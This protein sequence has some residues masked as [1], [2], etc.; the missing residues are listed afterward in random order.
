MTYAK[1]IVLIYI[2]I[3]TIFFL[4]INQKTKKKTGLPIRA[5]TREVRIAIILNSAVFAAA[6][7][8]LFI[9]NYSG[10]SLPISFLQFKLLELIG[11]ISLFISLI[12]GIISAR[13]LGTSWRFGILEKQKIELVQI[14]IY[15]SC[16]N[17][18]FLSYY[19]MYLALFFI[20]PSIVLFL[21]IILT[22]LWFHKMVKEEERYLKKM[23]GSRYLNYCRKVHRY[24]PKFG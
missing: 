17:P 5:K 20:V 10:I 4:Y 23:H 2:I 19:L 22:I 16:R 24:L 7:I 13:E 8:S 3:F 18:Y 11:I 9:P 14:G 1:W 21:L 15:R 6:L 12:I